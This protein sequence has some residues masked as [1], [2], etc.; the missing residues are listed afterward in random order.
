MNDMRYE[1]EGSLLEVCPCD[2]L[3]PCWVGEDPDGDGTC[4]AVIAY[5]IERGAVDGTDVSG[6]NFAFLNHFEGNILA[7]N[8]KV[9]FAVDDRATPQQQEGLVSA[10]TGKLGGPLADLAGLMGEIVGVE[11]APFRFEVTEGKGSLKIGALAE[12]EMEPFRGPTGQVTTLNESVFTTI[13]G[14]P[15]WVSKA[16]KYQRRT[17]KH[18][19]KDIDLSGHNAIQGLFRFAG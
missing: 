14:A 12:A 18:G 13:P 4:D 19:L 16:S 9:L 3:C 11:R 17:A 2:V 15:A 1:L 10:W 8:W 7:G 5:H 6:L